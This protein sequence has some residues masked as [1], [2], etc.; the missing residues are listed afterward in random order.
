MARN[1]MMWRRDQTAIDISR[2]KQNLSHRYKGS[3]NAGKLYPLWSYSDI[4][5]GDTIKLNLASLIRMS[6]PI[7]PV[8]DD[9]YADVYCFFTPHK[10]TMQRY[11]M[12]SVSASYSWKYFIGAQDYF[13]N[14]PVPGTVWSLPRFLANPSAGSLGLG[15][16]YE[17]LGLPA[18]IDILDRSVSSYGGY[19]TSFHAL[20]YLA[21]I[22][23][24][25]DFF[26]DENTM[27]P[28]AFNFSG[29][30]SNL[31]VNLYG[32]PFNWTSSTSFNP[33]ISSGETSIL[34]VSRPHGYF[35]SA[36]PWPQKSISGVTIPLLGNADVS[37]AG[38]LTLQD[39]NG[40]GQLSGHDLMLENAS[41]TLSSNSRGPVNLYNDSSSGVSANSALAYKSGLYVDLSQVSSVTINQLRALIAKQHFEEALARGGNRLGEMSASLFGVTPHDAGDDHSEY[42]GGARIPIVISEV[43]QTAPTTSGTGGIGV[44]ALGANSKTIDKSFLFEK[45]FD[46]WGTLQ[47]FIAFRTAESFNQG[48]PRRLSRSTRDD[49]YF[50][51]FARI[52]DQPVLNKEIF[53]AP[54]N[55]SGNHD[56]NNAVFGYQFAW[57]EYH[58]EPDY[59][60]GVFR[61]A[62]MKAWTYTNEF[63]TL[64]TLAG[65]LA[66]GDAIKA[67]VD[68]T[69]QASSA[70]TGFQFIGD[71]YF[72][73]EAIRPMPADTRPGLTRI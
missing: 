68:K 8:M 54:E 36:L 48:L 1:E 73:C 35:G 13:L 20:D 57:A 15:S 28:V 21:Y 64:P 58:Y 50:P 41:A 60:T 3:F 39:I 44:G 42:L 70:T 29:S 7:G 69:L 40:S 47:V 61:T 37:A 49:F 14:M 66:G 22:S 10:L 56:Q 25:N 51:A 23:V 26:R 19:L 24:W 65:Y 31:Y 18:G 2:S 53:Y 5:P 43:E 45:S 30:G 38:I 27:Q 9:M 59:V 63:A 34:P 11:S 55:V 67:N 52:G 72:D 62:P 4:L 12:P 46:T 17:R 32:G 71:F 33:F 6:T 16:F